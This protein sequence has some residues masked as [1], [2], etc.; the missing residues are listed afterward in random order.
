[1]C[2]AFRYVFRSSGMQFFTFR[3]F[4]HVSFSRRAFSV[5]TNLVLEL[6]EFEAPL[7]STD[8]TAAPLTLDQT[9]TDATRRDVSGT[10]L[11]SGFMI[12]G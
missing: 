1:M 7:L 12:S 3:T 2:E 11:R 4:A 6:A 8:F 9:A 10:V 5:G